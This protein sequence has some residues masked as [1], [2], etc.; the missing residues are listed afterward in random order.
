MPVKVPST[1][2]YSED[3]GWVSRE[4]RGPQPLV[5]VGLTDFGQD[6][7][8]EVEFVDLPE[9]GTGLEVGDLMAEIEARKATSELYAPL[10]GQVVE[11]NE[12]LA[13][14]PGLLNSDPYGEGW[15]CIL[16]P[17]RSDGMDELMDDSA[18]ERFIGG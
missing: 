2:R 7:L 8:G 4:D 11:V 9:P 13:D 15:L 16:A 3:H 1:L 10:A 6:L 18:Y 14:S 12:L 17:G 5:R